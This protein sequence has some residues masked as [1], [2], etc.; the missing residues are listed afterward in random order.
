MGTDSMQI[1]VARRNIENFR[2]Q[3][4]A[5]TDS[6]RLGMILHL[7]AEEEAKLAE[8][9]AVPATPSRPIAANAL[10]GH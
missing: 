7:L 9:L 2:R 8:L 6:K 3:A 1:Y 5:E 10:D 4:A